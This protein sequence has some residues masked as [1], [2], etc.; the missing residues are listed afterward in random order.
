MTVIK[1]A[2]LG[3]GT[4][5]EGLY[6]AIQTHQQQLQALLGAEVQ[7]AGV[8]IQDPYKKRNIAENVLVTT[9]FE[10][11]LRIPDL[12]VV[13]EAIVG[14]DPSYQYVNRAIERGCD[15]ITANKVMFARHGEELLTKAKKH[16][17]K[18]GYEATVAGGV[19]IIRTI[20]QQLQVNK[21]ERI[22][23]IVN[24]TSN[25]ILSEMRKKQISFE[26]ALETAQKLGYAEADPA[27]DIEGFDAFYKLMIVSRLAFG[28]QPAWNDVK[29]EGISSLSLKEIE[30]A[31]K[32]NQRFK[33]VAEVANVDG[34]I[35][36]SVQLV[37][38]DSDHPLYNVEG[39]DNALVI[40]S[41]LAGTIAV[42]G[43]GAGS[44]P[45]ASAMIEDFA[46]I[47]QNKKAALALT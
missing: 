11:I 17:V 21:I 45:T 31:G 4:V 19:P 30:E 6:E 28:I 35:Q 47:F 32:L 34:K 9:D 22:Q 12:Q 3:F 24:G 38:T 39:V 40:Q 25:F 18:I 46:Y 2:L 8:L 43:P 44:R 13:F 42:Q 20:A 29:V 37:I 23:A 26:E 41:S 16:R 7:V 27:N 33:H 14:E 10:E 36:A 15:V 5:G 1:A